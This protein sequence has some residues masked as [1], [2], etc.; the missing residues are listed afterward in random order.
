MELELSEALG[1]LID[2]LLLDVS[3]VNRFRGRVP[4]FRHYRS[5]PDRH[6]ALVDQLNQETTLSVAYVRILLLNH[7]LDVFTIGCVVILVYSLLSD[8]KFDY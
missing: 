1:L 2:A 6:A 5:L 4:D 3:L 8:F 7:V